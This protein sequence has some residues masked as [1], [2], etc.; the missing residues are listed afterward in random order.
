MDYYEKLRDPLICGT[1]KGKQRNVHFPTT[2][3]HSA[4]HGAKRE[5]MTKSI[6]DA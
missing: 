3:R 2:M 4:I 1:N 6:H 5:F